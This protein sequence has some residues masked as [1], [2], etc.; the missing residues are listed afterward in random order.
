MRRKEGLKLAT[1]SA[2][3]I[4]GKTLGIVRMGRVTKKG[5]KGRVMGGWRRQYARVVSCLVDHIISTE[6]DKIHYFDHDKDDRDG[7]KKYIG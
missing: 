5:I 4:Q 2:Q 6:A 7:T 3:A 1:M